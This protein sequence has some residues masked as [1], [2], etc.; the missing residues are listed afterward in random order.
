LTGA[1]IRLFLNSLEISLDIFKLFYDPHKDQMFVGFDDGKV[2]C[3]E[4]LS[5]DNKEKQEDQV[6]H[7]KDFVLCPLSDVLKYVSLLEDF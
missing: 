2:I 7:S 4:V 6:I 3:F 5:G 1:Y